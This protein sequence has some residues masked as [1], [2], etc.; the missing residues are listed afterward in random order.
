[1]DI[2]ITDSALENFFN[3]IFGPLLV[4]SNL[5][6]CKYTNRHRG[7]GKLTFNT[8]EIATIA[9]LEYNGVKLGRKSIILSEFLYS[10]KKHEVLNSKLKNASTIIKRLNNHDEC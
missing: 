9:M 8:A 6:K 5:E 3:Y 7:F 4:K 1:M 10:S 2:E